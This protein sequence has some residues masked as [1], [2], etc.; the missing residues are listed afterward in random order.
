MCVC[1]FA[2][3]RACVC[4]CMCAC[5]CAA[6]P[7]AWLVVCSGVVRRRNC[8][9][10]A[11]PITAI[12]VYMACAPTRQRDM[13]VFPNALITRCVHKLTTMQIRPLSSSLSFSHE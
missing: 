11:R 4:A 1:V 12:S 3:V 13:L 6:I 5:M 10:T 2:C 9:A 8:L 7:E